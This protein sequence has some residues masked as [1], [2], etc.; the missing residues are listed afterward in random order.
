MNKDYE[1]KDHKGNEM[2]LGMGRAPEGHMGHEEGKETRESEHT[3]GREKGEK[4]SNKS[5]F[6]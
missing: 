2:C 5:N 3:Q 6:C 4:R 1:T